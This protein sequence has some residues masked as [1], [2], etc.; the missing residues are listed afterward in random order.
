[1]ELLNRSSED[2]VRLNFATCIQ[3]RQVAQAEPAG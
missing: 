2:N 3:A 1:M